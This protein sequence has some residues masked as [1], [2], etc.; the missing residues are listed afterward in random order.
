M[1]GY[2]T[3]ES[4]HNGRDRSARVVHEIKR[5][6]CRKSPSPYAMRPFCLSCP[7]CPVCNAGVLWPNGWMD[8]DATCGRWGPSFPPRG[9][10]SHPKFS[11]H[12]CCGQ[13]SGWLKMPL[14][15][16]V[17][18]G[19]GHIVRW[20]QVTPPKYRHSPL[21]FSAHMFIVVKRLDG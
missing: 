3:P 5:V 1:G 16:E 10:Q 4:R 13:T 20:G 6:L 14:G 2:N 11:A 18:L 21:H 15:A 7:V 9:G 8:Q 12:V 17:G 19:P